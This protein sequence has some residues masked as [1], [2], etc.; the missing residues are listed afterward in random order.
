M[1]MFDKI[2]CKMPLIT[3]DEVTGARVDWSNHQYQ[4][5]DTP[6]QFLDQYE[7]R[8]DGTLWV[9]EYDVEDQSDPNAEDFAK[10]LG[11]MTRVN[12]R[13]VQLYDVKGEVRFYDCLSWSNEKPDD[14][15]W[16]EWS[17]YLVKG[18]VSQIQLIEYRK[19]KL[20]SPP[21]KEVQT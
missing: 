1:G 8:E 19:P 17:A 15:G 5:K 21:S 11:C 4:T 9:E 7:I 16:I 20:G 2:K 13:W 12:K 10:F 18:V 3:I 14:S 6:N